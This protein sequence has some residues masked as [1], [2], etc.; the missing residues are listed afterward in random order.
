MLKDETK[1][2]D[3]TVPVLILL[4]GTP[5]TGTGTEDFIGSDK[6]SYLPVACKK[7]SIGTGIKLPWYNSYKQ[8]D[9]KHV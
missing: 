1:L 9:L 5:N 8:M 3:S 2:C 4:T 7:L 6:V